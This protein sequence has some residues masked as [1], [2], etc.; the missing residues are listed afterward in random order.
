MSQMYP[1]KFSTLLYILGSTTIHRRSLPLNNPPICY[2][3]NDEDMFIY[4]ILP[5][6]SFHKSNWGQNCWLIVIF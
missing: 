1:K 5:A 3:F 4:T 2:F 6:F